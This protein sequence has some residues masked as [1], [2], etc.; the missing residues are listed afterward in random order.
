MTDRSKD[1]YARV[2]WEWDNDEAYNN[3]VRFTPHPFEIQASYAD[4]IISWSGAPAYARDIFIFCCGPTSLTGCT[5]WVEHSASGQ[6]DVGRDLWVYDSCS[7]TGIEYS[8]FGNS[9]T[10]SSPVI[11]GPPP[12]G[13]NPGP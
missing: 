13:Y 3:I 2:H 9:L 11:H 5:T 1:I 8:P 7:V 10:Q 4:R 6:V 12:P